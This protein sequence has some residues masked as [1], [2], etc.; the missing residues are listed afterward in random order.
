MVSINLAT[1]RTVVGVDRGRR[2]KPR[3]K[4]ERT[5]QHM[6]GRLCQNESQ[7]TALFAAPLLPGETLKGMYID[8]YCSTDSHIQNDSAV[9]YIVLCVFEPKDVLSG[10]TLYSAPSVVDSVITQAV[11]EGNLGPFEYDPNPA[12]DVP[13]LPQY[14]GMEETEVLFSE[15]RMLTSGNALGR[16]WNGITLDDENHAFDRKQIRFRKRIH[17][18]NGGVLVF[19]IYKMNSDAQTDFGVSDFAISPTQL[20]G[21]IDSDVEDMDANEKK[22]AELLYGGDTYIEADTLKE[23]DFRAQGIAQLYI[24]TPFPMKSR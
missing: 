9:P 19:G 23:D 22:G 24:D 12:G 13:V 2:G 1:G 18:K 11:E 4:G 10:S 6:F 3:I 14:Y 7:G 5:P 15:A 20:G 16:A 17:S 8:L 21:I